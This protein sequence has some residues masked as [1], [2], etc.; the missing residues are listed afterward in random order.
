LDTY[1]KNI[2]EAPFDE[3]GRDQKLALLMNGYNAFTLKLILEYYPVE[4]IKDIPKEKRWIEERW[5][6]GGHTWS[7]NQIEHEQIRPKFEEPRIH[8]ALVCAAVGCTP[9]RREA[10]VAERLDDQLEDQT[11]Y[12]HNHET[13]VR[14]AKE[15]NTLWLTELYNWYGG[16]FRQVAGSVLKYVA[17]YVPEVKKALDQ[18][19]APEIKWIDYDW[20]LNSVENAEPR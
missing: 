13:C 9:L 11:R 18:G 20:A 19:D 1:I 14:Y 15:K 5:T 7:L 10:F 16:D 12:V 17:R 3:M 6:I 8:F 4:S 2:R